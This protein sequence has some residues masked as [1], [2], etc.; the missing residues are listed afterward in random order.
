MGN[1]KASRWIDCHEYLVKE[2]GPRCDEKILAD[3]SPEDQAVFQKE[4]LPFQWLDYGAYLRYVFAAD[5]VMGKGDNNLVA[6]SS[7]YTARKHFSGIYRIFISVASPQFVLKRSARVWRQYFDVG[8]IETLE[9]ADK[10]VLAKLTGYPD[11]PL[12]HDLSHIPF[13]EEIL[14]MCGAKNPKGKHPKCQ[15]RGDDHCLWE[16]HWE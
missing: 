14:T 9:A 11:I 6:L 7:R 12:N 5:K 10:H 8:T 13:M 4:I 3:L 15:A 2:F 1:V 16:F